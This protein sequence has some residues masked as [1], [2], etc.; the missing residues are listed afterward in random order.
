MDL[1]DRSRWNQGLDPALVFLGCKQIPRTGHLKQQRF[2]FSWLWRLEIPGQA[3]AWIVTGQSSLCGVGFT[4]GSDS[5]ESACN[6]GNVSLSQVGRT[7]WRRKWQPTP[8]FLSGEFRGQRSLA[9]YSP[10]GHKE[11][12]TTE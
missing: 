2:I 6:V 3:L 12:D 5:K 1:W 11:V 4:G 10:W 9:S 7:P 8:V